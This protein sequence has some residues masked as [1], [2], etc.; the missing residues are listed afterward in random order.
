MF[1][2]VVGVHVDDQVI[3]DGRIDVVRM[4]PIARLGY[5]DYSV[6]DH[7]STMPRPAKPAD[8]PAA[9]QPIPQY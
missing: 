4:L 6:V 9:R 1:G 3:V 7:L 5:T 2:E 8:E